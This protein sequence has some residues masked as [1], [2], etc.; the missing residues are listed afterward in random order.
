MRLGIGVRHRR[1]RVGVRDADDEAARVV[2]VFSP[3][4]ARPGRAR[5]PAIVGVVVG[6]ARTAGVDLR[7]VDAACGGV[8]PA[9]LV[10]GRAAVAG[11]ESLR[12]A[13]TYQFVDS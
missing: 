1:R 3:R 2:G 9:R 10:P 8:L 6:D 7:R 13:P 12:P 5:L 4:A 11:G